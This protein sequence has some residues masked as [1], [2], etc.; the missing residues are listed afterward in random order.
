MQEGSKFC[1]LCGRPSPSEATTRSF[2]PPPGV[3]SNTNYINP[4]ATGPSYMPPQ[5][6]APPGSQFVTGPV[7]DTGKLGAGSQKRTI[8]VLASMV[9]VLLIAVIVMAFF[10]FEGSPTQ[11]NYFGGPTPPGAPTPPT[12]PRAPTPPRPPE[13]PP[14]PGSG[15]SL[16]D[17]SLIYPGSTTAVDINTGGAS[18]IQ[19][20]SDDPADKVIKW[21]KEKLNPSRE[22]TVPGPTTILSTKDIK[23]VINPVG[24]G[25]LITLKKGQDE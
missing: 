23:V 19:L 14:L 25:S 12:P 2:A 20:N 9:G 24:S 8:I 17:R 3:E 21:Y 1:R 13:A 15:T 18:V 6:I 11:D 22:V 10:L 16:I 4:A 7:A 5:F